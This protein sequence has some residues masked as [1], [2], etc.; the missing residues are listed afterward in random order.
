MAGWCA[1]ALVV[2]SL[3]AIWPGVFGAP[4]MVADGRFQLGVVSV[5]VAGVL[6][7]LRSWWSAAVV[8]LVGVVHL[9][10]VVGLGLGL[11]LAGGA[12]GP[13]VDGALSVA[14]CNLWYGNSDV[15]AFM[16]FVDQ[17]TPD[18]MALLEVSPLFHA[19][20][21]SMKDD[22]PHQQFAEVALPTGNQT[23]FGMGLVSK[24]PIRD[25]RVVAEVDGALP[26]LR[27]TVDVHEV[28]IDVYIVHA[29]PPQ[30]G[31]RRAYLAHVAEAVD[32]GRSTVV[33]GDFNA[34]LYS[35][36]FEAFSARSGLVDSRVGFG[37][38]ATWAPR[39]WPLGLGFDIDH[40]FVSRDLRVVDREVGVVVG[41]DHRPVMVTVV[42]S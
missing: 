6:L 1:S 35:P 42:G 38:Q 11:G 16:G 28:R 18:V 36:S 8:G 40:V 17:A 32:P 23:R 41:S 5:G 22:Y 20:I 14:S 15:P 33:L 37:R 25:F 4:E 3:V 30:S 26:Y 12:V 31:A 21:T 7:V 24:F 39:G 19:A 13:R 9:G 10:P 34:T 29:M 27:C 2:I